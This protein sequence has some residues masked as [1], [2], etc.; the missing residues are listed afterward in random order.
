MRIFQ[1]GPRR[2][3]ALFG[4]NKSEA[5]AFVDSI[6][7]LFPFFQPVDPASLVS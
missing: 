1:R 7:V 6:A 2:V 4:R 5:W 3:R